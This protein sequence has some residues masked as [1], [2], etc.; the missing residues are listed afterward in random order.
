MSE[1]CAIRFGNPLST[2]VQGDAGKRILSLSRS[3]KGA[4]G[5]L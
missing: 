4:F 5:V 2:E 1:P 3:L